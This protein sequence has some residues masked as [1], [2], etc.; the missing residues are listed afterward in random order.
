[1]MEAINVMRHIPVSGDGLRDSLLSLA[2]TSATKG[3][4]YK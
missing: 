1:M 2:Q 3:I 4:S